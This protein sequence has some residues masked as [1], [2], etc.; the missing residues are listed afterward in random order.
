MMDVLSPLNAGR[1]FVRTCHHLLKKL[2]PIALS[3]HF[4]VACDNFFM[5]EVGIGGH[6]YLYQLITIFRGA[7][8]ICC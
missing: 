6:K 4:S 1:S 3:S 2:G 5:L 7:G 8:C